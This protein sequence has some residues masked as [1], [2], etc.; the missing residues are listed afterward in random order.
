MKYFVVT[1]ILAVTF[2]SCSKEK[3]S[4]KAAEKM[5]DFVVSISNYARSFDSDF[6]IIPQNGIE[7]AFKNTDPNEGEHPLYMAAVNGFGVEELFYNSNY[8]PDNERLEILRQL[9]AS[10][11]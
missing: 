5:Q 4:D 6:I 7:L 10:K 1:F 8:S 9:K 11:K 3:L 2:L